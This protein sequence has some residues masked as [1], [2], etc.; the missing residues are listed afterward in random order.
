M[1]TTSSSTAK[2][3]NTAGNINAHSS[4]RIKRRLSYKELLTQAKPLSQFLLEY[5]PVDQKLGKGLTG[6]VTLAKSLKRNNELVAIKAVNQSKMTAH[7]RELRNEVAS[8]RALDHPNI[9]RLVEIFEDKTELRLILEYCTGGTLNSREFQDEFYARRIAYQVTR[10]LAHMHFRGI[11]HRDIKPE[12]IVFVSP[13]SDHVKVIDFGLSV[14]DEP[15]K[16]DSAAVGTPSYIAPEL[17]VRHPK[18]DTTGASDIWALGV[19]T[20]MLL[21]EKKA[22][23][24]GESQNEV[25]KNIKIGRMN[26]TAEK[27]KKVSPE[28]Q[29]FV[30]SCL[31]M[32]PADRPSADNLLH[33]KFLS[34]AVP[35]VDPTMAQDIVDSFLKVAK[36]GGIKKTAIQFL[37]HQHFSK[38][39]ADVFDDFFVAMD[40]DN[41]GTL[42]LFELENIIKTYSR[43]PM[44]DTEIAQLFVDLD[45]DRTGRITH[46]EFLTA[47]FEMKFVLT[48]EYVTEAFLY[49]D[50]NKNGYLDY[51]DLEY[52]LAVTHTPD[53]IMGFFNECGYTYG[54]QSRIDFVGFRKLMLDDI[55][56]SPPQVISKVGAG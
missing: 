47:V 23:F 3:N 11:I 16:S 2:D 4:A 49:L 41:T 35:H 20:Y 8:L 36:Y 28:A 5:E 18:I 32:N 24:V 25:L 39:K 14:Y 6:V 30:K 52:I 51:D 38:E 26:A 10:A 21:F 31:K 9:V 37:C 46:R 42:V 19:V 44:T 34:T 15:S 45:Q 54:K 7:L 53:V 29:D 40:K 17:L 13:T 1:G 56:G 43:K 22:P 50:R 55:P 48:E 27:W 33:H 12:N